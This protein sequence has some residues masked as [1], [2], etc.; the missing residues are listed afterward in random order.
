MKE[1]SSVFMTL[2]TAVGL[3][4]AVIIFVIGFVNKETSS[5]SALWFIVFAFI[6][7][8]IGYGLDRIVDKNNPKKAWL[9]FKDSLKNPFFVL[10]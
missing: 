9:I 2:G 4:I 7:R 8:V 3:T 1:K 5:W 6:G 10:P